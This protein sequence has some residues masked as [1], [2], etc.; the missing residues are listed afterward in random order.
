MLQRGES[1]PIQWLPARIGPLSADAI[2]YALARPAAEPIFHLGCQLAR[3]VKRHGVL[4]SAWAR[5]PPR[6]PRGS[7]SAAPACGGPPTHRLHPPECQ[8]AKS[9][10]LT[11]A[12]PSSNCP[13]FPSSNCPLVRQPMS[14]S[15]RGKQDTR[16][17]IGDRRTP[18]A[19]PDGQ[20]WVLSRRCERRAQRSGASSA[21][22]GSP[23]GG[24][25]NLQKA[26]NLNL[27]QHSEWCCILGT[28]LVGVVQKT[29]I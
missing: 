7:R 21:A 24:Q 6:G 20:S 18:E 4:R 25:F 17:T 12:V 3:Q 5:G 29:R 9:L 28:N 15:W 13:L 2:G 26:D 1:N 11:A 8:F 27:E 23:G 22:A 10:P 19:A 16:D 14:R